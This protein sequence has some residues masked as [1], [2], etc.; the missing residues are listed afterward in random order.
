MRPVIK[1]RQE[2]GGSVVEFG[3]VAMSLVLM[4][5]GTGV[6]GVN[7]IKVEQTEQV[8]HE[9][10][11]M[12]AAGLDL[13]LPGNQTIIATIGTDLGLST[14][15]GQGSSDV[16]LSAL[17]YVDKATCASD[18]QVDA[19]GNPTAGCTNYGQWVFTIR[20]VIGNSSV[21]SS[22]LGS[23]LTGGP[24]GVTINSDGTISLS[25]YVTKS[26]AVATFSSINPY[27]TAGGN[28]SGLPSGQ[29]LYIAE[30]SA[31][32]FTMAPYTSPAATYACGIF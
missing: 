21:H 18:G 31:L 13:S 29:F 16:I 28:V 30:A 24:T 3:V 32:T 6:F 7:L 20:L 2:R 19:Q 14:T 10:G 27:S 23:P 11:R 9:A 26:G 5:V 15:A 12:F 4:M 1:R 17:T 8:S 25:D 22:G